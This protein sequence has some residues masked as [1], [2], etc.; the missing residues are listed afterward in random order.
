MEGIFTLP[1]SEYEVINKLQRKLGKIN[2]NSFYI[3]TSRQQKGIDFILHN[4]ESNKFLRFQVKSS[5]SYVQNPKKLKNGEL[6]EVKYQYHLWFNN[7]LDKYEKDNADYYILFGLY[8]VYQQTK[9]IKSKSVFW[10]SLIMCF[11]EKEMNNILSEVKTK[12]EKKIDKFFGF[13]FNS[14]HQIFGTRGFE[15][16]LDLSKYLLDNKLEELKQKIEK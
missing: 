7:F 12:R 9:N 15:K 4:N 1:Y 3:P 14:S 11:S 2:G 5:R 6:T 10:K 13:G 16:D 8:P